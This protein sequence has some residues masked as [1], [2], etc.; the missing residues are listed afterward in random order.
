M[1]ADCAICN[2]RILTHSRVIACSFCARRFHANCLPYWCLTDTNE[3]HSNFC[4]LCMAEN[5]PFHNLEDHSFIA[6]TAHDALPDILTLCNDTVFNPLDCEDDSEDYSLT[7]ESDPD[8]QFY[9]N[10]QCIQNVQNCTYFTETTFNQMY[11]DKNVGESCLNMIHFNIRSVSK[12]L[13]TADIFLSGL[14]LQFK[15]IAITETWLNISNADCYSLPGYIMETKCR[16]NKTGGG[17][18]ML[19]R[20]TLNYLIRDDL[21]EFGEIMESL[22]IEISSTD[23]SSDKNVIIGVVYRP[24]GG[25]IDNF[26]A[27][28]GSLLDNLKRENKLL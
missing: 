15:I 3:F 12:N 10:F 16:I 22:F 21:T 11:L 28:F 6:S 4:H 24:P 17:V 23:I 1:L 5:F 20:H 7:S 26:N 8:L 18:A 14:A 25:N 27:L 9:N 19:I 13:T 2:T